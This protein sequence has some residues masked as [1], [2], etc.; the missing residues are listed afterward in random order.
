MILCIE[1]SSHNC[2]VALV[3]EQGVVAL[4]EYRPDSGYGHAESLH[5]FIHEMMLSSGV[6]LRSLNA[7]AVSKGPGS[8]TGLRIG[9]SAAK[10][11]CHGLDIP[12]IS[13]DTLLMMAE[14]VKAHHRADYFIPMIDARRMEVYTSTYD[15]SLNLVSPIEAVVLDESFFNIE[16]GK[17]LVFG[18]G[19]DKALDI[20][21]SNYEFLPGIFPGAEMMCHQ[22]WTK[23]VLQNFEDTA[24]FEPYYL[25]EFI[26]GK[27]GVKKES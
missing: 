24:Y 11:F 14:F 4:R 26:A 16:I 18:E 21:P 9:V 10:G 22:A 17:V 1:T 5:V 12:L 7:V 23:W 15:S 2:S 25:K 6:P 3:N 13:I 20:F 27:P 8:Y 19:S